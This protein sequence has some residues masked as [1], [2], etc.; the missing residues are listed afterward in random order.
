MQIFNKKVQGINREYTAMLAST[1]ESQRAFYEQSLSDL[2]RQ[3]HDELDAKKKK[4][5]LLDS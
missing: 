4:I 2:E 3:T 1:L 5:D